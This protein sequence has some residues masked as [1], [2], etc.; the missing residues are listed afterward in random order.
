MLSNRRAKR[1]PGKYEGSKRREARK[2]RYDYSSGSGRPHRVRSGGSG[3]R[4]SGDRQIRQYVVAEAYNRSFLSGI[5]RKL[6]S[7]F[8]S[9]FVRVKYHRVFSAVDTA[10]KN[11]QS[12]T[13]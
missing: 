1:R 7:L 2:G 13:K 3:Q 10:I 9:G 8:Y 11:F 6:R 5:V 4:R 12:E